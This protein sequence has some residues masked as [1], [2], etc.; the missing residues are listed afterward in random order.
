MDFEE[1]WQNLVRCLAIQY[2]TL[3]LEIP[4]QKIPFFAM[5]IDGDFFD[6]KRMAQENDKILSKEPMFKIISM[7]NFII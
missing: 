2:T 5:V 3:K 7:F 1:Q 6:F 4:H